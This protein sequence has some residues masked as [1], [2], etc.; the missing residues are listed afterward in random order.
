MDRGDLPDL[1]QIPRGA[2]CDRV[3]V[4]PI[5]WPPPGT[6]RVQIVQFTVYQPRPNISQK[7]L[8]SNILSSPT[9]TLNASQ[10][11]KKKPKPST[12]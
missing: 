1:G 4:G 6:G 11:V 12:R 8:T 9:E 3:L 10:D 2:R 7:D 5:E